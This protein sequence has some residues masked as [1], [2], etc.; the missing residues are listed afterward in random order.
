MNETLKLIHN[1]RSVRAYSPKPVTRADKD[2]ILAA[3][4][5]APTAGNLMLYSIIEVEDQSLKDR[6]AV[7]CD[8]QPFIARAPYVLLF[9]ADLQRWW[10]YFIKCGAPGR[11][12]ASGLPNRRP[13]TGDLMLACCDALISAQT[14]VIAAESLGIGSCYIGDILEQ[15]ETHREMFDLPPYTLPV[16]LLCFGY[17]TAAAAK[18]K[19]TSRFPG[20]SIVHKDR[21]RPLDA[22]AMDHCFGDLENTFRSTARAVQYENA[23]QEIYCRKFAA[24]FSMELNRSVGKM[25]ENWK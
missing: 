4:F 2:A 20:E 3:A 10:D 25:L 11:A 8:H 19:L 15:Y 13:Q 16:T 24:G 22:A 1:R 6:L 21:Y 17:P 5:R 7:S 14:A 18:R 9:L 12:E 23:G